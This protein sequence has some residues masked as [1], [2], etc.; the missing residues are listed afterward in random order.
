MATAAW[1]SCREPG[2]LRT[3]DA[4]DTQLTPERGPVAAREAVVQALSDARPDLPPTEIKRRAAVIFDDVVLLASCARSQCLTTYADAIALRGYGNPQNGG[5]LDDVF[6]Y[7]ILPFGFPDL[8]MLVVNKATKQPSPD[9]FNARRSILSKVQ[10][11]DVPLEQRRCVW[12]TGY[13]EILGELAPIPPDR[14]LYRILTPEPAKEREIARA[15]ANAINR[16]LGEGRTQTSLGKGYLG[17]LSRSELASVVNQLW[18]EQQGRCALT[19]CAFELRTEDDGGIQDDRL[20]LD[21]IDNSIGYAEGNIQLVTQF[22]NR[23]RG[24]LSVEQ[25]R[26]RLVQFNTSKGETA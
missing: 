12:F 4:L 10:V 9:A 19:G 3:M 18:K 24:T 25:A 7:A 11:D 20:S 22:A 23:A 13:E 5:W 26:M 8:T 16:V 15:V 17:S 2:R 14:Q 21:R 1:V 6:A